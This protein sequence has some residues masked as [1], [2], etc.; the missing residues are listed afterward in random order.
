M[1]GKAQYTCGWRQ[2]TIPE[3]IH[4]YPS[5]VWRAAAIGAYIFVLSSERV[6]D[7]ATGDFVKIW[8]CLIDEQIWWIKSDQLNGC[9]HIADADEF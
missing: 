4:I 1:S 8:K 6:Y 2:D 5:G 3:N 9:I 7:W